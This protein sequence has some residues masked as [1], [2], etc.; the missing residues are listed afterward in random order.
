M[1]KLAIV[2]T[3]ANVATNSVL[4]VEDVRSNVAEIQATV[5][6]VKLA[7]KPVKMPTRAIS[8]GYVVLLT[9]LNNEY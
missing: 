6:D 2:D 3:D 1:S 5:P 7:D 4:G 8:S 9:L